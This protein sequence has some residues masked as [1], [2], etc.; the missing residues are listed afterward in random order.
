MPRDSG[1][2]SPKAADPT[3]SRTSR[4]S[5]WKATARSSRAA[6]CAT[7]WSRAPRAAWPRAS[8]RSPRAATRPPDLEPGSAAVNCG[9][10]PLRVARS[11]QRAD[12]GK[13]RANQR[14]IRA[15]V[16]LALLLDLVG[17]SEQRREQPQLVDRTTQR[18]G[19]LLLRERSRPAVA[20]LVPELA[21]ALVVAVGAGEVGVAQAL[22]AC[23]AVL[24]ARV[25]PGHVDGALLGQHR[26]EVVLFLQPAG[27]HDGV[28]VA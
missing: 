10:R 15:I 4:P 20:H 25:G 9:C 21:G 1:S 7:N 17:A 28:P 2:S 19:A 13:H 14:R 18:D 3:F 5:G 22:I 12:V 24:A 11:A 26:L 16:G 27:G 23:H 8:S 6:V